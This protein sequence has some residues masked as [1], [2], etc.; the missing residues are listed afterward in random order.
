MEKYNKY[1][2]SGIEFINEIP[3]EWKVTRLKD[4]GFL[5]NGVSKGKEY[6]GHGFPF[7]SYGNI[8]NDSIDLEKIKKLANST[9][10]EQKLYSVLEGDIFFTRTSET[11]D[12]IGISATA[13]KIIPKATFSGFVIRLRPKKYKVYKGY[14]KFF[15]QG[16]INRLFL[17]K[18]ISIVTRASLSQSVLNNLPVLLPSIGEQTQIA[19]Y[20]DIKTTVIGNK[21]NLLEQKRIHYKSYRKTLINETITKGLNKSVKLKSSGVNWLGEIPEHWEVRRLKDLSIISTGNKNSEDFDIDGTYPFFVRSPDIKKINTFSFD[22]EAVLTAGDGDVG[23]IFHY[24]NGK[25]NVHQRVYC[26]RA[27]KKELNPKYFYYYLSSKLYNQAMINNSNSIVNS[28]R[29][30]LFRNFEVPISLKK[31]EQKLIAEYLDDKTTI[32]DKIV[33]NIETQITTLKELRKSLIN[34]VVTGKVKVSA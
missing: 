4:L 23:K 12:E 27:F 33:K 25:F 15:F 6:F 1:K 13:L 5:Q 17:S 10:E 26:V 29:L 18:Q 24:I 22:E 28:L 34:G 32:I 19:V 7:V 20:L 2:D 30:P 3:N 21:I 16:N 11:I 14:T 8:Y 31:E 9:K